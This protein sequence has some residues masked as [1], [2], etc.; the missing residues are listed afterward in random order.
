MNFRFSNKK[1]IIISIFSVLFLAII[2][3]S[4][5]FIVTNTPEPVTITSNDNSF[6]LIIPGKIEFYRK[7]TTTLDIY[8]SKDEMVL[9]SN[10]I[11]KQRD[12]NLPDVVGLEMAS[13][14]STKDNVENLSE[15]IKLEL[16]DYE[17]YKY[18]YTY[19]DAEYNDNFYTEVVWIVTDKNIYAL[20][21]QVVTKNQEKYKTLFNDIIN[22]FEEIA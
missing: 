21:L 18:S 2:G 14:Y 4:I 22:S 1:I 11:S 7:D 20:D 9:T 6:K 15:L 13:L 8:S 17:A 19:F 3:L 16:K 12:V 10:V 5:F